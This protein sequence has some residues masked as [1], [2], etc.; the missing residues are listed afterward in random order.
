M[1]P[2]TGGWGNGLVLGRSWCGVWPT[3]CGGG[4]L[5]PA[6]RL[7]VRGSEGCV[8]SAGRWGLVAPTRRS[9]KSIQPRAP[10]NQAV[11]SPAPGC[12]RHL[13]HQAAVAPAA[14]FVDVHP[15]LQVVALV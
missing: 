5:P 2:E 12:S 13:A 1:P 10:K 8:P 7:A 4:W 11:P 14:Q 15:A 6:T 9:R 3:C